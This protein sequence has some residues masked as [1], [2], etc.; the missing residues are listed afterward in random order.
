ME[1]HIENLATITYCL[2]KIEEILSQ[3]SLENRWLW[4]VRLKIAQYVYSYLI[5]H[6]KNKKSD[7]QILS[8]EEKQEIVKKHPLL[9]P[10]DQASIGVTNEQRN[11]IQKEIYDKVHKMY[12]FH[13]KL[14]N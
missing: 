11:K 2:E 3:S 1:K 7:Q 12:L 13:E 8:E 14:A 9:Q 10:F 5:L 4:E 6:D